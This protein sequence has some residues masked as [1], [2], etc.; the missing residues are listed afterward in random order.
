MNRRRL[1]AY[2]KDL[3]LQARALT[4]TGSSKIH[5][6]DPSAYAGDRSA[7]I[8]MQEDDDDD[9]NDTVPR[10]AKDRYKSWRKKYRKMRLK[11]DEVMDE[12]NRLFIAEHKAWNVAKRVQEEIDQILEILVDVN[13]DAKTPAH[14][15]WDLRLPGDP[16]TLRLASEPPPG[17]KNLAELYQNTPHTSEG[18]LGAAQG[19]KFD[20]DLINVLPSDLLDLD[21]NNTFTAIQPPSFLTSE[22]EADYL[23]TLDNALAM[24]NPL[25][26]NGPPGVEAVGPPMQPL[27]TKQLP[28]DRDFAHKCPVS[29]HSWLKK[30]QPQVFESTAIDGKGARERFRITGNMDGGDSEIEATASSHG[31]KPRKSL[32]AKAAANVKREDA[33]RQDHPF[34]ELDEEIGFDG[35]EAKG[36]RRNGAGEESYRPKGGRHSTTAKRKRAPTDHVENGGTVS[37]KAR[38]SMGNEMVEA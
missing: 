1:H 18:I 9:M 17:A 25:A 10:H 13:D 7:H 27:R 21:D 22:H 23:N 20:G 19:M 5:E 29:V 32:G 8:K 24:N 36:R 2:K 14:L 30:N 16:D 15:R 4:T 37:K 11:F 33:G 38:K 31:G 26:F 12:T 35:S 6:L 34:E 28:T 3:E